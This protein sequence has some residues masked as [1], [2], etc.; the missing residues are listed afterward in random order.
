MACLAKYFK[1]DVVGNVRAEVDLVIR[2]LDDPEDAAAAAKRESS[3]KAGT[4]A[5]A[6]AAAA[7]ACQADDDV[8]G[9]ADALQLAKFPAHNFILDS[10]E[11]F[12][13]QQVRCLCFFL[14]RHS[15]A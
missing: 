13:V 14:L 1:Q 2:R 6:A 8:G 4:R 12:L 5:A 10:S 9:A 3:A 7:A 15:S 11:D